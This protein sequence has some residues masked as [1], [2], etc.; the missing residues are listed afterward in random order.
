MRRT[1]N[2]SQSE[3]KKES[4]F[5]ESVQLPLSLPLRAQLKPCANLLA[6]F[7]DCHNHIYANEGLLKEKIFHEIVK[8]LL[9]KLSDEQGAPN[10]RVRFGITSSEQRALQAGRA[11]EFGERT[12]GLFGAVKQ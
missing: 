5:R 8:L 10:G 3:L 12:A 9:M 1:P 6:V 2:L 4:Q 7:Q 11:N